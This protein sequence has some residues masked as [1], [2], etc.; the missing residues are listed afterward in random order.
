MLE[1]AISSGLCSG[2]VN[3]IKIGVITSAGVSYLTQKYDFDLGIMLTAS[4]NP[5]EY[6]G[7]KIFNNKGLK[8]SS[9]EQQ[10]IEK[11]LNTEDNSHKTCVGY[12][13]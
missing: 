8:L 2:G 11:L 9:L 10:K 4:H 1:N 5:P 12:V 6:N 3:V 7:I 13:T